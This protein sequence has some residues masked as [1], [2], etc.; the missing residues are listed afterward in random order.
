MSNLEHRIVNIEVKQRNILGEVLIP[1]SGLASPALGLGPR[2]R[3]LALQ[4]HRQRNAGGRRD[5]TT[6]RP[7]R[8]AAVTALRSLPGVALSAR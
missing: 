8:R 1:R 3:D 2:G 6:A 4:G 5:L 7:C